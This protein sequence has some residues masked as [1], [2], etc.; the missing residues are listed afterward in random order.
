MS[1]LCLIGDIALHPT[2]P[3]LSN[4]MPVQTEQ[5][6]PMEEGF[7]ATTSMTTNKAPAN[8][9]K[10]VAPSGQQVVVNA[11]TAVLALQSRIRKDVIKW[12]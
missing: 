11:P 2:N 9:S 10:P 6:E 12:T 8:V 3:F 5:A 4:R 1:S 7:M